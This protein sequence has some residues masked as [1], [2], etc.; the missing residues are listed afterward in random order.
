MAFATLHLTSGR[1]IS[2]CTSRMFNL[3]LI[4]SNCSSNKL[5]SSVKVCLSS[6]S[7]D[8]SFAF[9]PS[10]WKVFSAS[11]IRVL[12]S[13]AS[14]FSLM[15]SV[16]ITL[17][18]MSYAGSTP[19]ARGRFH[20]LGDSVDMAGR[21]V[22]MRLRRLRPRVPVFSSRSSA[23]SDANAAGGG[24]GG[25]GWATGES[26]AAIMSAL[27]LTGTAV[28]VLGALQESRRRANIPEHVSDEIPNFLD[29]SKLFDVVYRLTLLAQTIPKPFGPLRILSS[30]LSGPL[31]SSEWPGR[32][33]GDFY[34]HG[35]TEHG[36]RY[37]G[38]TLTFLASHV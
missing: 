38:P 8:S 35:T 32:S 9:A 1:L 21:F 29:A 34:H 10:S 28:K 36:T 5:T 30:G 19:S 14:S 31:D 33:F 15:L 6:E 20:F 3:T 24:G 25:G 12:S 2:L 18:A 23:N 16:L 13:L 11:P 4:A 27:Y 22:G 37:S 17:S 7:S 26:V